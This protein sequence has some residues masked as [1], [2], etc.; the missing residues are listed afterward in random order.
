MEQLWGHIADKHKQKYGKSV[1][2]SQ[3]C[4]L[5]KDSSWDPEAWDENIWMNSK[6][7]FEPNSADKDLVAQ[8]LIQRKGQQDLPGRGMQVTWT[9]NPKELQ[10]FLETYSQKSG[11]STLPWIL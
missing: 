7:E 9:Y 4:V 1:L 6:T 10:K 2:I 3:V 8:P 11:K 5:L